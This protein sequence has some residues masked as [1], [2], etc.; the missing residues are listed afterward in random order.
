MRLFSAYHAG[1]QTS[2]EEEWGGGSLAKTGERPCLVGGK[3]YHKKLKNT[4]TT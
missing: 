1:G 2:G 4:K 3:L